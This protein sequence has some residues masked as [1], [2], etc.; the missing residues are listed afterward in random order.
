MARK[1]CFI[2]RREWL[3]ERFRRQLTNEQMGRL[4][5]AILDYSE[6]DVER[7]F[8]DDPLLKALWLSIKHNLDKEVIR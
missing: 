1:S 4:F 5:C 3:P 6:Y 7:N 8:S 2:F